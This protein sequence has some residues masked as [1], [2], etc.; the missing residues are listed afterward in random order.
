MIGVPKSFAYSAA[1]MWLMRKVQDLYGKGQCPTLPTPPHAAIGTRLPRS[2][3]YGFIH[4]ITFN[5]GAL[6]DLP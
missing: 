5:Y 6:Y 1:F 3:A 2:A 4:D